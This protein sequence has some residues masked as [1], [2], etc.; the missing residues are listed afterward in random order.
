M[1]YKAVVRI[2]MDYACNSARREEGTDARRKVSVAKQTEYGYTPYAT[3]V[4][5]Y[6]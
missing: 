6:Y 1:M 5:Y 3:R 2:T 4:L